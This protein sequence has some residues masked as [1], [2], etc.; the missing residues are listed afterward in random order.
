MLR[1]RSLADPAVGFGGGQLGEVTQA[2]V[3]PKLKTP[4]IWPTIFGSGPKSRTKIKYIK[5]ENKKVRLQVPGLSWKSMV[6]PVGPLFVLRGCD[7][8]CWAL[9]CHEEIWFVL[10]CPDSSCED[11][12]H[13]AHGRS[14]HYGHYG[15]CPYKFR[16][17]QKLVRNARSSCQNC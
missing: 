1:K 5:K 3:P 2:R 11:L 7:L 14:H 8:F 15:Q 6:S 13:P 10:R 12:I 16:N 4:R 9:V 17:A